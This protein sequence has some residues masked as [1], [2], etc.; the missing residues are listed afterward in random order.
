M[1]TVDPDVWSKN[2]KKPILNLT[3]PM[4]FGLNEVSNVEVRL[5]KSFHEAMVEFLRNCS[6][7]G[8]GFV[9]D[10]NNSNLIRLFYLALLLITMICG[11]ILVTCNIH[12]SFHRPRLMVNLKSDR[13]PI[14]KIDFPAVAICSHNVISR[15]AL[16]DYAKYLYS[17]D[18]NNI[19]TL[20]EIK[21]NLLAFGALQSKSYLPY[22]FRFV[23]YLEEVAHETNITNILYK[24]SPKCE[25]ML[26]RC[27][28]R[29]QRVKCLEL[30][31]TRISNIGF[32]CIFNSRF[33]RV[34][35]NN[36]PHKVNL[37]GMD[38]G[39]SVVVRENTDDFMHVL[40]V[41][42]GVE[43]ILFDGYQFP[44]IKAGI[45]RTYSASRNFLVSLK[46]NAQVQEAAS[47]LLGYR[48]EWLRCTA[49]RGAQSVQRS[50]SWCAGRCRA[51]A[52]LALCHC[53]PHALQPLDYEL[54]QTCS[55]EH[56]PCLYKH[57]E[58]FTFMY[59]GERVHES[60]SEEK[61][62]SVSCLHCRMNCDRR[63]YSAELVSA[64][65]SRNMFLNTFFKGLDLTNT[66]IITV[67][68]EKK[69]QHLYLVEPG[70]RWYEIVAA[71]S[72]QCVFVVGLTAISVLEFIY[73]L[74]FRWYH[75]YTTHRQRDR[76]LG[77]LRKP[78]PFDAFV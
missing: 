4:K 1:R 17:L 39:L 15:S 12:W 59:P 71:I 56:L 19:F 27:S 64:P 21:Q 46:L 78:Q 8:L 3:R 34:D 76:I 74:T 26:E 37:V 33:S 69:N 68:F 7:E 9:L 52:A 66:T 48:D 60:L 10:K 24:L 47:S 29:A 51:R 40:R 22:D 23:K 31:A 77:K 6:A 70:L 54:P 43:V 73:H 35:R 18:R 41:S 11:L 38:A 42:D 36:P 53:A 50:W 28:W 13:N 65:L 14:Q 55:L 30:F 58:K 25:S 49:P 61:Q 45:I 32:C 62:D 67:S 75:H 16:H 2:V 63:Q 20:E 44:L 72:S 57:K 5:R